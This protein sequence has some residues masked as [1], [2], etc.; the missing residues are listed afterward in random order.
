MPICRKCGECLPD[1]APFCPWC[2]AAQS[3][4]Q[5][6]RKKRGNGQGSVYQLPNKTWIAV[7]VLGY[8]TA[9]EGKIKPIK[10]TKSGFKTKKEA[11]AYLPKLT[12]A[13]LRI[14][15]DITFKGLYDLWL[16]THECKGRSK[17]TINCYKAAVKHYSP[18]W[19][20]RFADLGIDDL[21]ECVDDCPHGKRTRENMKALG[22]LLYKYAIPRGYAPDKINFAE[23]LFVGGKPGEPREEFQSQE[24]ETIRKNLGV[25]PYADYIYCQI[26]LGF[27]PHEFLTLDTAN[28]DRK[29]RCLIGGGKTEAGTDR[30]VT[31]SPKIQPIIDRLTANKISG[32]IFCRPDGKAFYDKFYR[33]E[34]FYPAL[35]AMGLPNPTEGKNGPRKLTPY[36]CRHTFATLMKQIEAPDK[37]KLELMGHTSTEMLRHYQHV[38]YDDFRRITDVL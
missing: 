33:E 26:Y 31:I 23:Y 29:E 35:E 8:E 6:G 4:K 18:I 32:P 2:G 25:V 34:C 20:T 1:G 14:N 28:Y 15:A 16:P 3:Q 37:D 27:R 21:Q 12:R 11:L 7:R 38:S 24:I 17:G 5:G 13:P 10:A 22:T 9:S 19:Y 36:C 30:I